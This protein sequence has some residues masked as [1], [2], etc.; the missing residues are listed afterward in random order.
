MARINRELYIYVAADW[1]PIPDNTGS[2]T[3]MFAQ[4]SILFIKVLKISLH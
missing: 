2:D 4:L 1:V 3:L